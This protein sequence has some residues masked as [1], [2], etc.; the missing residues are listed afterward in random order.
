MAL[1]SAQASASC[2]FINWFPPNETL[3]FFF[4]ASETEEKYRG[5]NIFLNAER[6]RLSVVAE[7]LFPLFCEY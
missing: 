2:I 4:L 5:E 3:P 1:I 7:E 6:N